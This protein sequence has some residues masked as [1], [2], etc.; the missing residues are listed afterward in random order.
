[1]KQ[2]AYMVSTYKFPFAI[3][4]CLYWFYAIHVNLAMEFNEST[5]Q[6]VF[7]MCFTINC[8]P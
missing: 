2:V 6:S 1:M 8:I 3:I 4:K 7:E 5:S